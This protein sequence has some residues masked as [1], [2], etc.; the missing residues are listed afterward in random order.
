MSNKFKEMSELVEKLK[1]KEKVEPKA[2]EVV[3]P[4]EAAPEVEE[5]V[6]EVKEPKKKK[7]KE[8]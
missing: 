8:E 5:V 6:E 1:N 2:K 3:V 7:K 4:V